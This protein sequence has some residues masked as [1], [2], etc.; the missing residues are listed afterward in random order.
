MKNTKIFRDKSYLTKLYLRQSMSFYI[1]MNKTLSNIT[2]NVTV[3][4]L[5][6]QIMERS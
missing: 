5:L 3:N 6:Y 2:V 1:Y 4:K